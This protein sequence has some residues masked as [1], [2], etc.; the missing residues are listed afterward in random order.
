MYSPAGDYVLTLFL[1][2][3]RDM[4]WEPTS[5]LMAD[6]SRSVYNYFNPPAS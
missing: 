4:I 6:L 2:N 5:K 3:D 1:Y